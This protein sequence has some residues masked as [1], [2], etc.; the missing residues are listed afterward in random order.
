M[1]AWCVTCYLLHLP[2]ILKDVR[3]ELGQ[4]GARGMWQQVLLVCDSN[5]AVLRKFRSKLI[6]EMAK[7]FVMREVIVDD[8]LEELHIVVVGEQPRQLRPAN[9]RLCVC[10]TCHTPT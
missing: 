3:L 5:V 4:V 9:R 2:P 8:V 6:D 1:S 10:G 7:I